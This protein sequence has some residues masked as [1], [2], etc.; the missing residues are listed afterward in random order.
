M[1]RPIDIQNQ[2]FDKKVKGYDVDQV[3]DFL[4]KIIHD[5]E[6]ILKDNQALRDKLLTTNETLESYRLMENS[7]KASAELANKTAEDIIASA[8]VEAANI[9]ERAKINAQNLS[10][11]IDDVHMRKQQSIAA[12]ESELESY[13]V[14]I[15][16]VCKSI[17][18][19]AEQF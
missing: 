9:I 5:Y 11:Q 18:E 15:R 19:I 12:M 1:L 14:R 3:D 4:D 13:R 17:V 6:L 7:L 10:R 8:K 2:S 16:S